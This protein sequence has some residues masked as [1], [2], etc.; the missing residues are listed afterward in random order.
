MIKFAA[1]EEIHGQSLW[2]DGDFLF[3]NYSYL[4]RL[5]SYFIQLASHKRRRLNKIYFYC[6]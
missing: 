3:T 5:L 4:A 2:N 6:F 1:A